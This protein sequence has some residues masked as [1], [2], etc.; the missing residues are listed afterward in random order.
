MRSSSRHSQL[1]FIG[2]GRA[3]RPFVTASAALPLLVLTFGCNNPSTPSRDQAAPATSAEATQVKVIRPSKGDVRRPIER[4]GYNI[5]AYERT[6]LYAKVAGYV[7]KWNFDLGDRVR[8]D[9]I[10]AELYVPEME[11]ELK[12]K[13]A[14]VGQAAAEIKQADAAVLRGRAELTRARTQYERLSR[15]TA[16]IEKDQVDEYRLGFDAAQATMAKVEAD[17]DVAKARLKVAEADRDRVQTMLQYTKI[18]APFDGIVTG[19]VVSTGDFVQPVGASKSEAPFVVEKVDPVRVFVNVQE[20]EAV[21]IHDGDIALIRPQGLPGQQFTGKVTRNSGTLNP[22][23]RT[24]RTE[25]DLRNAEGKL[26]PGMY[27]TV[28][29]IAEHKNVWT[30][31]A[32]AVAIQ[33]EQA[34]CY[35]VEKGKAV[36]TNIRTGIRNDKL[37]EILTKETGAPKSSES[38]PWEDLTGEEVIVENAAAIMKDGQTVNVAADKK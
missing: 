8:K 31:P 16:V 24:L 10:L 2:D 30:L 3:R 18:P 22:Q 21:W 7:R 11:V 34:Y 5:E 38:V 33:G 12:Q 25:I 26:L 9:D 32:S 4:P 20:L 27:V 14:S 19:R 23:N 15:L 35:R 37:V 29:I 28:T 17:L 1:A 6:L 36:R 13:E